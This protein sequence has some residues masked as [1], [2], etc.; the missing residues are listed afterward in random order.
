MHYS[1]P[2]MSLKD[3]L[4]YINDDSGIRDIIYHYFHSKKVHVYVEYYN[5][6][7]DDKSTQV[8]EVGDGIE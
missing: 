1:V 7:E 8:E 5:N 6:D 3:G 4:R 2:S